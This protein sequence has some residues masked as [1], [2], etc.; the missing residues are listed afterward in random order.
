M[1][2]DMPQL[3]GLSL[4]KEGYFKNSVATIKNLLYNLQ[5]FGVWKIIQRFF[6]SHRSLKIYSR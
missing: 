2:A 5:S 6:G 1:P 3:E 4:H